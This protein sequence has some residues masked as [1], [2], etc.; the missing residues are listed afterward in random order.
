[1][2]H[3]LLLHLIISL[4]IMLV[5]GL[6]L[7]WSIIGRAKVVPSMDAGAIVVDA[8]VYNLIMTIGDW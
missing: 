6:L 4:S 1:M 2:G 8:S 3:R 7:S 5:F